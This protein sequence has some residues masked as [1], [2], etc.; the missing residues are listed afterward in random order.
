MAAFGTG[1]RPA[2][3]QKRPGKKA[4]L[5]QVVLR[6]GEVSLGSRTEHKPL[7]NNKLHTPTQF[8]VDEKAVWS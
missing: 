2:K 3:S 1:Y 8:F 7:E 5:L 4:A 6:I